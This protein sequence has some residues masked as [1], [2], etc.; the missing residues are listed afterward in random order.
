VVT[1]ARILVGP[2][3]LNTIVPD[4]IDRADVLAIRTD[5]FM[6][7]LHLTKLFAL[8]FTTLAPAAEFAV[9]A[10]LVLSPVVVIITIECFHLAIA[11]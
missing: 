5:D 3:Q 1:T 9:E 6:M 4:M 7:L 11:P 2:G 8:A 10:M